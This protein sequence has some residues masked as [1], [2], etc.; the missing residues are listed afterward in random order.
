[1]HL[2]IIIPV[3]N[4][5]AQLAASVTL[6]RA[7]LDTLPHGPHSQAALSRLEE[8]EL[9]AHVD[10]T[11]GKK[12]FTVG[13][14]SGIPVSGTCDLFDAAAGTVVARRLHGERPGLAWAR[15]VDGGGVV[16][17][18]RLREYAC[19][20]NVHRVITDAHSVVLDYGH[21]TRAVPTGLSS[22]LAPRGTSACWS[23]C[24]GMA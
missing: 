3:Y 1:M 23:T 2:V 18:E 21:A 8:L 6:L 12:V 4:E 15:L 24:S 17:G 19:D 16:A 11:E 20:A 13:T 10:R 22:G 9:A 14:I 7:Y 5:E